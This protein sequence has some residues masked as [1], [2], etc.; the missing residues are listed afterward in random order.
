MKRKVCIEDALQY[1]QA[2][3]E[4]DSDALDQLVHLRVFCGPKLIKLCGTAVFRNGDFS[5]LA[6]FGPLELLNSLFGKERGCIE[7]VFDQRGKL[8][9]FEI[10]KPCVEIHSTNGLDKPG[11]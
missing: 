9:G 8:T 11:S 5:E 2:A 6:L 7:P 3:V 4:K 1:L 10:V